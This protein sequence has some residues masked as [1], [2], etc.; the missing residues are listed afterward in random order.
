LFYVAASRSAQIHHGK[1]FL[2]RRL[3][4]VKPQRPTKPPDWLISL[5]KAAKKQ[6]AAEVSRGNPC[7][8]ANPPAK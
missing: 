7:F 5:L 2:A 8:F 1:A 3:R 6:P 4:H